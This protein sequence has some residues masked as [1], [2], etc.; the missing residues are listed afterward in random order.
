MGRLTDIDRKLLR[1][2]AARCKTF[3]PKPKKRKPKRQHMLRS[4]CC[5]QSLLGPELPRYLFLCCSG[6]SP[7]FGR[8]P[9]LPTWRDDA[10]PVLQSWASSAP[11]IRDVHVPTMCPR[12]EHTLVFKTLY[13]CLCATS[14]ELR[15]LCRR[16]YKFG[17][18]SALA[19][20]MALAP[21]GSPLRRGRLGPRS[22]LGPA[23][24]DL[25]RA[26]RLRRI[27][28]VA[29]YGLI[30]LHDVDDKD[31]PGVDV[32]RARLGSNSLQDVDDGGRPWP[33]QCPIRRIWAPKGRRRLGFGR[34]SG[35][36]A[37]KFG[38]GADVPGPTRRA[39]SSR[40]SKTGFATKFGAK[41]EPSRCC[42][43]LADM[44][45]DPGH[46]RPLDLLRAA[47]RRPRPPPK[48]HSRDV[49]GHGRRFPD[50]RAPLRATPVTAAAP[51][52]ALHSPDARGARL[53]SSARSRLVA[54]PPGVGPGPQSAWHWRARARPGSKKGKDAGAS[55]EAT[56]PWRGG[57]R[58][59]RA[60]ADLDVG[61]VHAPPP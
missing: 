49:A 39:G 55:A 50:A 32:G 56:A 28:G 23:A 12:A 16:R 45:N 58:C 11:N 52:L 14:A 40:T 10:E 33:A 47:R 19:R 29:P 27:G 26:L 20:D 46:E 21:R 5:S 57:C 13:T 7:G 54:H 15:Q 35:F 37:Q 38:R 30:S 3:G 42:C 44:S 34:G 22:G 31:R 36:S 51:F 4:S 41:S 17:R 24:G 25:G 6:S 60:P 1:C 8:T 9:V 48:T 18:Q 61:E 43:G 53:S 59:C 2:S